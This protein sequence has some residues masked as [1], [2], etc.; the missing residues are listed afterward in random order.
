MDQYYTSG[1]PEEMQHVAD[2]T[3]NEGMILK[4]FS[5]HES[6]KR[7]STHRVTQGWAAQVQNETINCPLKLDYVQ[8]CPL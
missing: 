1:L 3:Q 6:S 5:S 4:I 7:W 2:L 8:C